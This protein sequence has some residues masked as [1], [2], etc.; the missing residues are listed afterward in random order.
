MAHVDMGLLS[1][2]SHKLPR[3]L[4]WPLTCTGPWY[5]PLASLKVPELSA[6]VLKLV[7]G[8][9]IVGISGFR[10]KGSY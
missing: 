5:G 6:P 7:Y 1:I 10:I 2:G 9:I 3:N 4:L 8:G